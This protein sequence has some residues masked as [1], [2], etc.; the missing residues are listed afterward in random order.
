MT[1]ST[2]KAID[3]TESDAYMKRKLRPAMEPIKSPTQKMII[4]VSPLDANG[5]S[6]KQHVGAFHILGTDLYAEEVQFRP[7]AVYNK[8][9][10]M[11]QSKNKEGG[12]VW[13]YL[14]QT[15]FFS[16]YGEVLYDEKGGIAC[17]KVLGEARKKLSK[18]EAEAN[19][20]KAKSYLYLYGLVKFPN[21]KEWHLVDFRVGGKRLMVISDAVS[22]KAIG[23]D[24][25]MSQFI[26]DLKCVPQAGSVHPE[27]EMSTDGKV[28]DIADILHYDN[29]ITN[30]ID[31]S[32]GRIMAKF[33][34]YSKQQNEMTSDDDEETLEIGDDE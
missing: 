9:I 19:N 1:K 11:V 10:K 4:N 20:K 6:I 33:N 24:H 14:N 2:A 29:E 23:K 28:H 5:K 7:L 17:G 31:E 26:Y 16:N 13:N 15:V 34:K 21:D 12:E 22:S 25:F 3:N 27:L 8:L 32:N 30:F 18:D